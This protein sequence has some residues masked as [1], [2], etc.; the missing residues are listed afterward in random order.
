[1]KNCQTCARLKGN[2]CPAFI[3]GYKPGLNGEC[4]AW[5]NNKNWKGEL[6]EAV[7]NYKIVRYNKG[8]I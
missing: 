4:W 1:M 5:T 7:E 3:A 6:K 2:T 8:L